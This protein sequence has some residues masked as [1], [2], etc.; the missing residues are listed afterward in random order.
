M[1]ETLQSLANDWFAARLLVASLVAARIA[2]MLVAMPSLSHGLSLRLKAVL[3]AVMTFVL[4][5]SLPSAPLPSEAAVSEVFFRAAGEFLFGMVIGGVV[6]L[7]LTGIQLAGEL[8]SG[9]SGTQLSTMADPTSGE[10]MSQLPR[11]LGVFVTAIFFASGGHRLLIDALLSSFRNR[12]PTSV[13]PD[14]NLFELLIEQLTVGMEAGIRVAA[15]IL[16][17]VLLTNLTVAIV[18]RAIPQLNL[19]AL[20]MNVHSLGILIVLGLTIGSAGLMFEQELVSAI[21]RLGVR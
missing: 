19:L 9:A 11:L 5:P 1:L 4:V 7:L 17:C 2:G 13:T 10:S 12:P 3:V 21:H 18:G 14:V 20:G 6:Q 16:A 15:P 8:I